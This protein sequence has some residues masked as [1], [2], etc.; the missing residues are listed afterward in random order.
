MTEPDDADA[1]LK[2]MW[3][4]LPL[5]GRHVTAFKDKNSATNRF[6]FTILAECAEQGYQ[7]VGYTF[8][9][10]APILADP[11]L[12]ADKVCDAMLAR[13]PVAVSPDEYY[14]WAPH[15]E[16]ARECTKA[17]RKWMWED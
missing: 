10:E 2:A 5:G 6:E 3:D 4:A 7:S 8:P 1:I 17:W 16:T 13:A 11:K 15:I 12:V 14:W 9:I